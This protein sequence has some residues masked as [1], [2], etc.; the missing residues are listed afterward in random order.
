[1]VADGSGDQTV[2]QAFSIA[3]TDA[4][5]LTVSWTPQT[6][7]HPGDAF[8]A[9]PTAS[10]GKAAFYSWSV[11][12][13]LPGGV[14]QDPATGALS[15]TLTTGGSYGPIA[16]TVTDGIRTATTTSATFTVSAT[17]AI[18]GSPG[19][20]AVS[21]EPYSATF[22]ATGGGSG[23]TFSVA[24]G[25]LPTWLTLN[26][27]SG[28]L[29]GTP[30]SS[31]TGTVGPLTIGV[32]DAVGG[33]A[34]SGPFSIAVAAASATA[35]LTSPASIR[36]GA[37]IAGTL[38]SN[39]TAPA[40]S[41]GSTPSGP[42]LSGSGANFIGLAPVVAV[43]TAYSVTGTATKGAVSAVTPSFGLT[44]NPT[45]AVAGG[46]G[47]AITGEVGFP[48]ATTPAVSY[49]VTA[50][51]T[52]TL[53]VMNGGA[54][55]DIAANCGLTLNANGSI[56]GTP[57]AGCSA[58]G[59]TIKATDSDGATASTSSFNIA[60]VGAPS[61]PT[62]TFTATT[63]NGAA[64]SSAALVTHGGTGPFTWTVVTGTPPTGLSLNATTGTLS[65][66]A[67]AIGSYTFTVKYTDANDAAS[68]PSAIPDRRRHLD[69]DP[70]RKHHPDRDCWEFIFERSCRRLRRTVA[71]H[72]VDCHRLSADRNFGQHFHRPYQR[73]SSDTR[74]VQL[75]PQT[76]RCQRRR[77]TRFVDTV[78]D[79]VWRNSPAAV[80]LRN[81]R[82]LR[83]YGIRVS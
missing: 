63:P 62:G 61:A 81:R 52:P 54:A 66:T 4:S 45:F 79:R 68:P 48:I 25:A 42:T 30:G 77:R 3:V 70:D 67:T 32:A 28:V 44:V 78:P 15:G 73:G 37:A 24:S 11:S 74:D 10:G 9:T 56:S 33:S 39:L 2:S 20:Q 23:K 29:S 18:T 51:G 31:D 47:S 17:L 6:S 60:V 55:Y 58:S 5:P 41:F 64:Y 72:L 80:D 65:G 59:L 35:T 27:S 19:Q 57:T 49:G 34:A 53:A 46:P 76:D 36:S 16:I 26:A 21:G 69:A 82:G 83:H 71:V 14:S 13:G 38:A 75:R 1:M 50:V 43:S 8:V 22:S 7:F 40:W 12:G